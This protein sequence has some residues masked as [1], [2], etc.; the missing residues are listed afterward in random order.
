MEEKWKD[1]PGYEGIYQAST[2]GRI[3]SLPHLIKANKDGGTR[4]TKLYIKKLTVG[5]HGYMYVSLSKNGIQKTCLLHRVVA[6]T[7]IPNPDKLPAINHKDGNKKNN[8]VENLEWC[9]DSENQIHASMN[10]LFKKTK[11]VKCLETGKMYRN[12]CEAERKTGISSRAI[13]NVC[14]GKGNTAGGYKW[15]WA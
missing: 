11:R 5:W 14:V 9:T 15:E 12:S 1:I 7:F 3:K 6:D 4:Y 13:R 8:H 2:F 10:G